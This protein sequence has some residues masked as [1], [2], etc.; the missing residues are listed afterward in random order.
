MISIGKERRQ[1]GKELPFWWMKAR[2][3]RS[4]ELVLPREE[5]LSTGAKHFG[6][7]VVTGYGTIDGRTV[8]L[9]AHDFTILGGSLG[10][11]FGKK[12]TK[13]MDLALKA[14]APFVGLNDSG[15]ARIQEGVQSLASYG[16]VF[17]R[18]TLSS[19]VIPQISAIL[20]PCCGRRRLL[21]SHHR[22]HHNGGQDKLHV[23][24]GPDVVKAA[25]GEVVTFEEL[26]GA[27]V[28]ATKSGDSAFTA[29]SEEEC[30]ELI[31]KL[32]SFLPSNCEELAPR[33]NHRRPGKTR[34]IIGF[35]RA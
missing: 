30:M 4:T 6:D 14:G 31:R 32:L 10:E 7:G 12:I 35:N 13:I 25:L 28:H 34:R 16:E 22:L 3:S 8:Y 29:Y 18:N 9:F 5:E 17:F 33:I 26:G 24:H 27:T 1:R 19:G 23:R 11:M 2:S 20:G 15:G 21:A